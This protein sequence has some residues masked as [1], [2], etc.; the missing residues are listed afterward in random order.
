MGGSWR[1][2]GD[3]ARQWTDLH[4]AGRKRDSD[5]RTMG[6][7]S[8]SSISA[9]NKISLWL[10][11]SSAGAVII[12]RSR[13]PALPIGRPDRSWR[14]ATVPPPPPLPAASLSLTGGESGRVS[15]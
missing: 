14:R 7:G 9:E 15:G 1:E 12:I 11:S 2:P 8:S 4:S 3:R 10:L 5:Q 6:V 13:I